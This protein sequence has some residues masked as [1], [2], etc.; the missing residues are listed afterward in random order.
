MHE[1]SIAA[2]LVDTVSES[3][4]LER[5]VVQSVHLRVGALAGVVP[6]ALLFCYEAVTQGTPLQGSSLVIESL[7]VVVYCPA[8]DAEGELEYTVFLLCPR[9][10]EPTGDLRQGRE[11]DV[12]YV[13]IEESESAD[14]CQAG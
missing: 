1:L 12:A 6:E 3:L 13:E 2:S 8:C 5:M 4:D 7:P 9:C 14:V 10:G 11:L